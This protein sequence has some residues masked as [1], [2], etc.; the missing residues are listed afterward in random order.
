MVCHVRRETRRHPAR[1]LIGLLLAKALSAAALRSTD[2]Q[3]WSA[4]A[5][6]TGIAGSVSDI[7]I[8]RGDYLAVGLAPDGCSLLAWRS[9]DGATWQASSP[10]AQTGGSCGDNHPFLHG[11]RVG[12]TGLV[13]FG[14]TH[15]AGESAWTSGDGLTWAIHPQDLALGGNVSDFTAGG[16]GYVAVGASG[17]P[18]HAMVWTSPDGATWTRT[19]DQPSLANSDMAA[20]RTLGDG[21][22][23]AVGWSFTS[24]SGVD[25]F[26]A[27]TST[28]GL[29]WARSPTAVNSNDPGPNR[30]DGSVMVR[31]LATDGSRLVAIGT[32]TN[33]VWVSPRVTPGLTTASLTVA[34][35]GRVKRTAGM[36]AGTCRAAPDD[37]QGTLLLATVAAADGTLYGLNLTLSADGQVG[38]FVFYGDQAV[39]VDPS[40]AGELDAQHFTVVPGSTGANGSLVFQ[41]LTD[42]S[43]SGAAKLSGSVEWACGA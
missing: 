38:G 4:I 19:P 23:V 41:G 13:G 26:T 35:A 42:L 12:A 6:L 7:A 37:A 1:D 34:L 9:T 16:P 32:G 5:G 25:R 31:Q 14:G 17:A 15:D 20:V 30:D 22:L 29:T 27:W 36:V 18:S 21:T 43:A 10:F 24:T 2:G 33:G 28:D 11:V 40:G 8:Y 3:A 39:E